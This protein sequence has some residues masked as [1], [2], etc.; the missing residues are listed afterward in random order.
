MAE[1]DPTANIGTIPVIERH[2]FDVARLESFMAENV[3][4]FSG[5]VKPPKG[6]KKFLGI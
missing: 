1:F 3:A 5:R 6:A 2:K 4:G